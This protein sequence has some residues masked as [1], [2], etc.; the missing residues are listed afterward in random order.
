MKFSQYNLDVFFTSL[1]RSRDT[2]A[3]QQVRAK[4]MVFATPR[5]ELIHSYI[6]AIHIN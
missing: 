5:H 3:R 6:C 1:N 4:Q 2:L